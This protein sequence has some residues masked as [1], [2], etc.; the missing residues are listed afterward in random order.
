MNA[1]RIYRLYTEEGL[2]VRTKPRKR[3]APWPRGPQTPVS[4]PHQRWAMACVHQRLVDGRWFRVL[5]VL[6][7]CPREWRGICRQAV[8]NGLRASN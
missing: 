7:Q 2:I 3:A 5:T 6:D 4:A 8:S 1:K